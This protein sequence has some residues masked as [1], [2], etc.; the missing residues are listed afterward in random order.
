MEPLLCNKYSYLYIV[1]CRGGDLEEKLKEF[2]DLKVGRDIQE[3]FHKNPFTC[4]FQFI[5][6]FLISSMVL[7]IKN[8]AVRHCFLLSIFCSIYICLKLVSAIFYQIFI[9]SQ[10]DSPLKIMKN[11]FYFI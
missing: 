6:Y 3:I 1:S 5:T 7:F 8:D 10:Y 2:Y 9:F 4:I 11:V